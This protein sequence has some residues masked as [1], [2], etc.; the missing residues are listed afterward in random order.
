MLIDDRFY[1]IGR[2]DRSEEMEKGGHRASMEELTK[3]LDSSKFTV[4]MDHQPCDYD[5]QAASK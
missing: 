2:Q 3:D 1:I 5:A 4:V